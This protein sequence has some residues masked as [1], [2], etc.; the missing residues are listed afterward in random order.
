MTGDSVAESCQ[1]T[2]LTQ[3][4]VSN[5]CTPSGQSIIIVIRLKWHPGNEGASQ[6]PSRFELRNEQAGKRSTDFFPRDS[7][8]II[9]ELAIVMIALA[10]QPGRG[11]QEHSASVTFSS[12]R[13]LC[14]ACPM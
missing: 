8:G 10:I 11:H 3:R 2:L 13:R 6:T 4:W 5:D 14:R 9:V 7:T 1:R 12:T